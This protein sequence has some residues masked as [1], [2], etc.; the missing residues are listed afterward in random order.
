MIKYI[1]TGG[2]TD[3]Q[4]NREVDRTARQTFKKDMFKERHSDFYRERQPERQRQT[5]E[6]NAN[7]TRQSWIDVQKGEEKNR[8]DRQIRQQN[9]WTDIVRK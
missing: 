7:Q 1:E 3:R 8:A 2:K 6:D 4:R 5:D 9:R